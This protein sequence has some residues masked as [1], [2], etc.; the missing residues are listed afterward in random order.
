VLRSAG[1]VGVG[2]VAV[3]A[4]EHGGRGAAE[5]GAAAP[6]A[7]VALSGAGRSFT[8]AAMP[9]KMTRSAA[10]PINTGEAF[11]FGAI[12]AGAAPPG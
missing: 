12:A 8:T 2:L 9:R 10:T 11:C 5:V 7:A 3:V 1:L 4:S 6:S